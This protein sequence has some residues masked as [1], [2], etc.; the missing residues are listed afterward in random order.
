[1]QE[2]CVNKVTV[3]PDTVQ[4][5]AVVEAKLTVRPED[6]VALMVNGPLLMRWVDNFPKLMV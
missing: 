1:V 6:A 5:V 3:V 4:I 2:P